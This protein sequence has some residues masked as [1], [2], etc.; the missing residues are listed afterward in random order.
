MLASI[1][2]LLYAFRHRHSVASMGL[3]RRRRAYAASSNIAA[4][5]GR[6]AEAKQA[7]LRKAG[8]G[9]LNHLL[10][11]YATNKLTAKDLCIA[12]HFAA[13]A[14]VPG[15]DFELYAIAPDQ[16]TAGNY[17]R[18]LDKVLPTPGPLYYLD[19]PGATRGHGE[20]VVKTLP[21]MPLHEALAR[22]VATS[23]DLVEGAAAA[24]LTPAYETNPLVQAAAREGR[25]KPL[26]FVV[27]LDA[28]RFT[29]P[30]AGR[31]D[32]MLGFWVYFLESQRRH[33]VT[34]AR[35]RDFC[36]CGCRGW[37]T[38]FPILAAM[39][40]S[41]Q[42]AAVGQRPERRHDQAPFDPED[43]FTIH[44]TQLG[45]GLGFT[46]VL[47]WL[48]GDWGGGRPHLRPWPYC[49]SPSALLHANYASCSLT[50][51]PWPER[52]ETYYEQVCSAREIVVA[53]NDEEHRRNLLRALVY[54]KG[55]K[56]RGRTVTARVGPLEPGDRL[57]PSIVMMDIGMLDDAPL[58]LVAV[59]WR[60]RVDHKGVCLDA[61]VNRTPLF[62]QALGTNP[63]RTLQ[64][65]TLHTGYYG[66]AMRWTSAVI[67]RTLLSTTWNVGGSAQE[68]LELSCRRLRADLFKWF[69]DTNLPHDK[70]LGDFTLAMLGPAQGCSP[71]G[72]LYIL[73]V[74]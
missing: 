47:L 4:W 29:A 11:L 59:F 40:W 12:C 2:V 67:W 41:T 45:P 20:R 70:R 54:D 73:D 60:S 15:G 49:E 42:A 53:V 26:A 17:Q 3:K 30:L 32:S 10:S 61:V 35:T 14:E 39:A 44:T 6:A 22:E 65:D 58:P 37:C 19:V 7:E 46:G 34:C 13:L 43:P 66:P 25:P 56:G 55:K 52:E 21:M 28:V 50:N 18:H 8:D 16:S 63:V 36:R 5:D 9:L 51:W 1:R 23:P 38:V 69:D 72:E 24:E 68:R 71:G 57:V 62:S 27:Y 33:L 31:T 48:K 74:L 64:I